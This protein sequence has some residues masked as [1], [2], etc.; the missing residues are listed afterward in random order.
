[1]TFFQV[2]FIIFKLQYYL[3]PYV[4][5]LYG[6]FEFLPAVLEHLKLQE[7]NSLNVILL[8]KMAWLI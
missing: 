8:T 4:T 3:Y 2:F 5:V 1:M 7:R 6:C